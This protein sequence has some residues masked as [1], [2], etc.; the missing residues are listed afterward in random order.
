MLQHQFLTSKTYRMSSDSSILFP[1]YL[2]A[3]VESK[4]NALCNQI[5]KGFLLAENKRR[6]I[7]DFADHVADC[8]LVDLPL[9]GASFTWSNMRK[10]KEMEIPMQ[11]GSFPN[12]LGLGRPSAGH[13]SKSGDHIRFRSWSHSSFLF[14]TSSRY[15]TVLFR[16]DVVIPIEI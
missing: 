15:G 3:L 8:D 13:Y 12:L 16:T 10:G 14:R 7:E 2:G 5:W 9:Y 1:T 4:M 11:T 6:G